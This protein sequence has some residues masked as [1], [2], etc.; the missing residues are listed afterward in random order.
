MGVES[1]SLVRLLDSL[2]A[3][4]YIVRR[5]CPDDRRAKRI[6]VTEK[7]SEAL[8]GGEA[9]AARMRKRLLASCSEEDIAATVRVLTSLLRQLER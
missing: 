4:G 9:I 5:N 1:P 7:A 2:E 6:H 3:E 8:L